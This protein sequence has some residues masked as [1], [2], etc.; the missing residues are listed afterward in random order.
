MTLFGEFEEKG[1]RFR[2]FVPEKA[3]DGIAF[4][5]DILHGKKR[6]HRIRVPML[7]EPRFGPDA[8]DVRTLEAVTDAV[9]KLLPAPAKFGK[10]T[11]AGIDATVARIAI[12][13]L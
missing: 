11:I 3:S 6:L 5:V 2:A 7:Y 10:A 12:A 8:G 9:V 1:Y 4:R 13:R